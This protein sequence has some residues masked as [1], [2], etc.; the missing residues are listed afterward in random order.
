M[1]NIQD[2]LS[3]SKESKKRI[4]LMQF[5]DPVTNICAGDKNPMLHCYFVGRKGC[6]ARCTDKKGSFW[7]IDMNVIYPGHLNENKRDELFDPVWQA[8]FGN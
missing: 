2:G 8:E 6:N 3:L 5:G 1:S 4:K 7:D